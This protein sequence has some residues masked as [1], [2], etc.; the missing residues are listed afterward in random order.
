MTNTV[1]YKNFINTVKRDMNS[2]KISQRFP[3]F[4]KTRMILIR[5]FCHCWYLG[6]VLFRDFYK[7]YSK[8]YPMH[9][10]MKTVSEKYKYR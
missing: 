1:T 7:L 8:Y 9:M 5:I 10:S 4:S 6:L 3:D 2:L